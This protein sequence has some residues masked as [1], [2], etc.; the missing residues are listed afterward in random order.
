MK[1]LPYSATTASGDRFAID[2]PLH[3]QTASPMRV[4]QMVTAILEAIQREIGVTGDTS[5]GDVLQ[6]MAMATAIRA[7]MIHAPPDATER[8]ARDLVE[9]ALKATSAADRETPQSGTA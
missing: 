2:F 8:I 6:A 7:R 5:N 9:T 1:T 4:E 3:E